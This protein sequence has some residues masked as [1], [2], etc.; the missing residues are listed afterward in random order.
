MKAKTFFYLM[1]MGEMEA[2]EQETW[3]K[4]GWT[5]LSFFRDTKCKADLED[6]KVLCDGMPGIG[7]SSSLDSIF[8][9]RQWGASRQRHGEKRK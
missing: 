3:P 4:F 2:E 6:L 7:A 1:G 8:R 9:Q 5:K